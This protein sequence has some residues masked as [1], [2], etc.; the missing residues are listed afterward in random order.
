MDEGD[1]AAV[2]AGAGRLVH[3]AV[4]GGAAAAQGGVEVG[5]LVA[6]VVDARAA[7]RQE[8]GDGAVGV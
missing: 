6:D 2:G 4:A 7:P 1:A 8:P 3:Q 5:H